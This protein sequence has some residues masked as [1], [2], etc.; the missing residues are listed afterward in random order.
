[1]VLEKRKKRLGGEGCGDSGYS[2]ALK[3]FCNDFE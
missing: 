1:M 2:H 3:Q